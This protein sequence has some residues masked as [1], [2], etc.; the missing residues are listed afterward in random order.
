MG[1]RERVCVWNEVVRENSKSVHQDRREQRATHY[2]FSRN[3]QHLQNFVDETF[4][5]F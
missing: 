2:V 1:G 4:L 3:M 5:T